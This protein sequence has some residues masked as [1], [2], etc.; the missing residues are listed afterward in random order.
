MTSTNGRWGKPLA[1][2]LATALAAGCSSVDA[3]DTDVA[4]VRQAVT[5]ADCGYALSAEVTKVS[6]KDFKAK[7]KIKN[8]AG[9][10]LDSTGFTVLVNGGAATLDKVDHGT[11]QTVENGYLLST[12]PADETED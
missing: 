5:G 1:F 2:C 8:A 6:K 11:F 9:G 7:I 4:V 3:P 10:H 12:I